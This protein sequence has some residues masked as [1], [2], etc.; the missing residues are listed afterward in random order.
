VL[1][2]R[3][4][5]VPGQVGVTGDDVDQVVEVMDDAPDELAEA[6]QLLGLLQPPLGA[7]LLGL[8]AQ[9]LP[10]GLNGEPLG[11]VADRHD[12]QR[13]AVGGQPAEADLRRELGAVA[14]DRGQFEVGAH[15]PGLGVGEV[16][17]TVRRLDGDGRG[18]DQGLDLLAREFAAPVPEQGLGLRMVT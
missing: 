4:E 10:F 7:L 9:P 14:A 8:G 12:D 11:D 6:L 3:A 17:G 2:Q 1:G 16:V 15:R 18:R 5:L 13:L